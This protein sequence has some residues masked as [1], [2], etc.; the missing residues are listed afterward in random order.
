[1]RMPAKASAAMTLRAGRGILHFL[2]IGKAIASSE[3]DPYM[4]KLG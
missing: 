2:E 1:M 4:H 3:I